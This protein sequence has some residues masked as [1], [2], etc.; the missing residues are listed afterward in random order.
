MYLPDGIVV[1]TYLNL[2]YGYVEPTSHVAVI[3]HD[4]AYGAAQADQVGYFWSSIFD[5]SGGGFPVDISAGDELDIYVDATHSYIAVGQ[6]PFGN[7]DVLNDTVSGIIPGDTGGTQ[8]T[9]SLGE[10]G[11]PS[12]AYDITIDTDGT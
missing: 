2:I 7:V 10:Y 11:L 12:T 8:V 6:E 3:R 4:A 9:I 5:G 1:D